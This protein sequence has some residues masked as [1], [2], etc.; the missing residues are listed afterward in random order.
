MGHW[1]DSPPVWLYCQICQ[2]G[3]DAKPPPCPG[4]VLTPGLHPETPPT[5]GPLPSAV[6]GSTQ[7]GLVEPA[8]A[9][10]KEDKV[11]ATE[12][13][14]TGQPQAGD[15]EAQVDSWGEAGQLD[16]HLSPFR[17]SKVGQGGALDVEREASGAAGS[18]VSCVCVCFY[19]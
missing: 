10:A 2:G 5:C 7:A 9:K 6:A 12:Q 14:H 18:P 16:N 3:V 4:A 13:S 11:V 19:V 17:A 1:E 8:E 15:P